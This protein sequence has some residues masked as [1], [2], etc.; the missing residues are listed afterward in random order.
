MPKSLDLWL[1]FYLNGTIYAIDC[2]YVRSISLLPQKLTEVSDVPEYIRGIIRFYNDI[3]T[4]VGLRELFGM[5]TIKEEIEEFE[6]IMDERKNDHISWV[7]TLNNCIKTG[8][9]FTLT[10]D[11]HKCK[12]GEWY[13]NYKS[14]IPTVNFHLKKLAAPHKRLHNL[15]KGINCL[16]S[17]PSSEAKA[18]LE[19]I[20]KNVSNIYMPKLINLI[21]ETKN[22][23]SEAMKEMMVVIEN[24]Q[25]S[26]AFVMDEIIGVEKLK[27][28]QYPGKMEEI[29]SPEYIY[30]IAQSENSDSIIMILDVPKILNKITKYK[31]EKQKEEKKEE[32]ISN[33][34]IN[35]NKSFKKVN[36]NEKSENHGYKNRI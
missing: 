6:E 4:I 33:Q 29:D 24:T 20:S 3:I 2:I 21:D 35:K 9:K 22:V 31:K 34:K 30:S 1:T 36:K 10:D 7:N 23:Y 19:E 25:T 18:K 15:A 16:I 17:S 8:D 12:F 26:S 14:E 5:K 32:Q 13:D 28:I 11:P 27:I